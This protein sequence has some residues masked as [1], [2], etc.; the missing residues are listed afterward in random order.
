MDYLINNV[1]YSPL[2]KDSRYQGS[3]WGCCCLVFYWQGQ[4]KECY[5]TCATQ[6]LSL[7]FI[8]SYSHKKKLPMGDC[9]LSSL[10]GKEK[11]NCLWVSLFLFAHT[12][13]EKKLS[14][15][16]FFYSLIQ[17]KKTHTHTH[18][19]SGGLRVRTACL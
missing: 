10:T 15:G 9:L 6:N 13:K 12:I 7:F 19:L 18:I 5:K 8:R 17:S 11:K 3:V 2:C 1:L 14:M 4:L 16:V